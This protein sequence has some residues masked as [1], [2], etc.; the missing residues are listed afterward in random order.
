MIKHKTHKMDNTYMHKKI[1]WFTDVLIP[2]NLQRNK[3]VRNLQNLIFYDLVGRNVFL[4]INCLK[5]FSFHPW[6][7]QPNIHFPAMHLIQMCKLIYNQ[8]LMHTSKN[9]S[10]S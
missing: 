10:M 1:L 5:S 4:E 6:C 3:Y 9:E 7:G 8:K 2:W